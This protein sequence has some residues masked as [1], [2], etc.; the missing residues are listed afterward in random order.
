M[1]S[2]FSYIYLFLFSYL[3]IVSFNHY[4]GCSKCTVIG[5]YDKDERHMSYSRINMH[6]RTN[7]SFRNQCDPDHHKGETPLIKLQINLIEDFPISDS[8]HLLDLGI[9]KRSLLVWIQGSSKYRMKFS[10]YEVKCISDWLEDSNR[11]I[12]QEIHRAVRRLDCI[13]FWKGLEYRTFMM[14]LGPVILKKFLPLEVYNHF[15]TLFCAVIICSSRIYSC[16]INVAEELFKHYIETQIDIYGIDS[17]Y[18]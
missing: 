7:N 8:L 5:Q 15:L 11:N 14:Y 9:M 3:R 17:N 1:K 4:H 2:V 16:Y 13:K 12:P 6:L 10:A 18:F